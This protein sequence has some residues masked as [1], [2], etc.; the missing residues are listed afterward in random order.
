VSFL[1]IKT[2]KR[3]DKIREFVAKRWGCPKI[4]PAQGGLKN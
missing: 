4:K 3:V 1:S 2:R